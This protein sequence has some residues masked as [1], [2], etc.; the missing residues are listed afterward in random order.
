MTQVKGRG[1]YNGLAMGTQEGYGECEEQWKF[2]KEAR[3]K[4]MRQEWQRGGGI[5]QDHTVRRDSKRSNKQ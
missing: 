3:R 2:V 5:H 1:E 4:S